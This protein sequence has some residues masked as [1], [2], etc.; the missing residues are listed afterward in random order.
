M[1]SIRKLLF[2]NVFFVM[3]FA[4]NSA[5]TIFVPEKSLL[6]GNDEKDNTWQIKGLYNGVFTL[7]L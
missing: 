1:G 3:L 6:L 4:L 2:V 5:E 7:P